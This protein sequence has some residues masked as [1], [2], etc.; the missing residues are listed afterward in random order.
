MPCG[1]HIPT[2]KHNRHLTHK[3][4]HHTLTTPQGKC[5]LLHHSSHVQ[6]S[7]TAIQPTP[8]QALLLVYSTR[9]N[10]V[11]V[12]VRRD[13]PTTPQ[14]TPGKIL[15]T[16]ALSLAAVEWHDAYIRVHLWE[17]AARQQSLFVS[18][19]IA[20]CSYA[21]EHRLS[22]KCILCMQSHMLLPLSVTVTIIAT[23]QTLPH[24]NVSAD[25]QQRDG[26]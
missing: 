17:D 13:T 9:A 2:G 15:C 10:K 7:S 26:A 3:A 8:G 6:K 25:T 24:M 19:I 1:V 23:V 11:C 16:P 20:A 12:P 14:T 22:M 21:L 5:S 18:C 4:T